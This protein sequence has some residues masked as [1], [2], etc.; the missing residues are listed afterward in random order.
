MKNFFLQKKGL[1]IAVL[2]D[3]VFLLFLLT[4]IASGM[5]ILLPGS[6]SAKFPL[7]LLFSL[8]GLVCLFYIY[9][10]ENDTRFSIP[11]WFVPK[12]ALIVIGVALLLLSFV[13]NSAFGVIASGI[14]TILIILIGYFLFKK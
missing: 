5:E 8:L 10:V 3:I 2:E 9:V 1:W 4:L 13:L 6:V 7:S 11:S 12:S 14:Q